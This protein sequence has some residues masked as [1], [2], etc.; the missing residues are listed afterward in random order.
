LTSSPS[1]D[2]FY[3]ITPSLGAAVTVNTDFSAT[4]VDDRQARS[5]ALFFVLSREA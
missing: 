4:D 2:A 1:L 3:R 5:H